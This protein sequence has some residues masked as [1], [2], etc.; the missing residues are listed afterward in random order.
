MVAYRD[1]VEF[2]ATRCAALCNMPFVTA[3]QS[4]TPIG[5]IS[6]HNKNNNDKRKTARFCGRFQAFIGYGKHAAYRL[7][8]LI[9]PLEASLVIMRIKSLPWLH[10]LIATRLSGSP[11]HQPVM[12]PCVWKMYTA[13]AWSHNTCC[14]T[15]CHCLLYIFR[16]L[17]SIHGLSRYHLRHSIPLPCQSI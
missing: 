13:G 2:N 14:R 16:A 7:N 5:R 15:L 9:H 8:N 11:R 12:N 3:C 4:K 6:S 10:I 17:Y 1:L